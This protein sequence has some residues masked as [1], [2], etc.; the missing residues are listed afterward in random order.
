MSGLLILASGSESRKRMLK[1][2]G[3]AFETV[4]PVVNED[5][6]K[7]ALIA[8]KTAPGE[9]AA[10]LAELKAMTVSKRRPDAI[11]LSAD[12]LLVCDGTFYDK[13][14]DLESA[15]RILQGLRKRKHELVTA[16]TVIKG[17]AVLWRHA[18]TAQM[19]MRDFSDAFLDAYVAS[20]GRALLTCVGCY[21]IE[22]LGAQL[23]SRIEGDYFTIQGLP[24]LVVL[25]ALREIGV[26]T[27]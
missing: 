24:L 18:D 26:I 14:K 5:E 7:A 21:R 4:F 10:A 11:V 9:I 22:G 2:A 17:S 20:E 8:K 15:K 27:R 16:A 1:A 19:W 23:F 3:I 12:Q 13:A 25:E 6:T